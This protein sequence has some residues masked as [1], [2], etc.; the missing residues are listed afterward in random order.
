MR[1]TSIHR[2]SGHASVLFAL[3]V[4]LLF[5]VF[6][7]ASDGA[8]AIQSKAR[9]E[10]ASEVAAL[11][12]AARDDKTPMS[13]ENVK[14]VKY[15]IS[16]YMPDETGVKVLKIERLECEAMPQC[17]AGSRKGKSR[18]TQYSVTVE[19]DQLSWFGASSKSAAMPKNWKAKGGAITRKFQGNSV[20]IMFAAD[21]SGS[22]ESNWSGGHQKKYQDL[23]QILRNVTE[24]L[25]KYNYQSQKYNSTIGISSFA[26]YPKQRGGNGRVCEI[27]NLEYVLGGGL[28][29]YSNTVALMWNGRGCRL[30]PSYEDNFYDVPLTSNFA[31][32]NHQVSQFYARGGTASYQGVMSAARM[33]LNGRNNKK[34]LIVISDGMDNSPEHTMGLVNAGMCRSITNKIESRRAENGEKV[35]SRLAFI[36]FDFDTRQNPA[37]QKCVGRKNVF[38]AQSTD[39]L[40]DQILELIVEEVGHLADTKRN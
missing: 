20:D 22:M 4:P 12:V 6:M 10:D 2:Q 37:L 24:E 3:L 11:A 1:K 33:L 16:E 36:G 35:T 5:G 7:L 38:K 8:R 14:L 25:T 21:F 23:I 32:F 40:L 31:D 9:I 34:L 17:V 30:L 19:S 18:Y 29:H 15:Y 27:D 26:T 28:V 13:T 39:E